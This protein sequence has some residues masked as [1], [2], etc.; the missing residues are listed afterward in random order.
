MN[1]QVASIS[2]TADS[3]KPLFVSV[4]IPVFNDAERLKICLS[5]LEKQTYPKDCYE[6]IVI[7]NGSEPDQAIT[8]IAAEFNQAVAIEEKTPGSYA[9]RNTGISIAKGEVIAFT[10]SDCIPAPDWIEQ[11]VAALRQVP[12]CGLVAGKI[13]IFFKDP[14]RANPVELY[15]SITAFPQQQL[16]EKQHFAAAGNLFTFKQVIDKVGNFDASLKSNGDVDWGQ[17]VFK[18][19]YRQIY[20]QAASVHHPA[21]CTFNQ[22]YKRTIR[23]AGGAYDLQN[24]RNPSLLKR[25]LVFLKGLVLDLIPPLMFTF[26]AFRDARLNNFQ[27]KLNVSLVMFFIRYVTAW[28]K[29][30]L[31]LGA[32]SARE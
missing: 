4:I 14:Q 17:R 22:L 31:K 18:H 26:N 25:N 21:R 1:S 16:L 23:L 19:G 29:L 12:N 9:A 3:V 32:V 6:V 27:Q 13:E 15:E 10:D 2:K 7:D 24:R 5:A 20:A 30:R 11:G 28:E 8:V